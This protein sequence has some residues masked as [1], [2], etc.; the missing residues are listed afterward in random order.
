VHALAR[1]RSEESGNILRM[2]GCS[3]GITLALYALTPLWHLLGLSIDHWTSIGLIGLALL[4]Y[5]VELI[6]L[7]FR[8]TP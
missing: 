7:R 2:L 3:V 6:Y 8:A 5:G 1:I 4:A